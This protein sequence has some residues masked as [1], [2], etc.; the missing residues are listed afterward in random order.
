MA[1]KS[2]GC[3]G[4]LDKERDGD[5]VGS[6]EALGRQGARVNLEDASGREGARANSAEQA[7]GA[8]S[9]LLR[10]LGGAQGK[11]EDSG[12]EDARAKVD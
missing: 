2:S 6:D 9:T 11:A 3:G 7:R 8:R 10:R 1:E 4:A 12:R 5:R